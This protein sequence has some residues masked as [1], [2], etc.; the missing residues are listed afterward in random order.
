MNAERSAEPFGVKSGSTGD[1]VNWKRA[2]AVALRSSS[3]PDSELMDNLGLFLRRQNLARLLFMD[4]IYK[5]ILDVHGVVMEF[6]VRWGQNISLFQNLRA[7]YEPFNY[8]RKI[9]GFDTFDG[10]PG[11][12]SEDAY[13]GGGGGLAREIIRSPRIGQKSWRQF[14]AAMS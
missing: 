13:H 3:I 2:Q 1:E 4:Q 12:S 5:M 11:V 9:I 14:C 8:N 7:I 6:G 10:F